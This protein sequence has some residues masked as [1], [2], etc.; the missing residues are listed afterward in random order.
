MQNT[1]NLIELINDFLKSNNIK[2]DEILEKIFNFKNNSSNKEEVTKEKTR[3]SISDLESDDDYE[4]LIN[5]LNSIKSDMS[6]LSQLIKNKI[7]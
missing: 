6:E 3:E 1:N 4:L 5:K 2:S 7:D